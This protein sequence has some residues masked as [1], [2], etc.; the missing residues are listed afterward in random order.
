MSAC[1]SHTIRNTNTMAKAVEYHELAAVK[2]IRGIKASSRKQR[3][4]SAFP[5]A[6]ERLARPLRMTFLNHDGAPLV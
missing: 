4:K 3:K 5:N 1:P 2:R 6:F